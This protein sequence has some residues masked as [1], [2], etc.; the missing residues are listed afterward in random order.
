[1]Y[2]GYYTIYATP[3]YGRSLKSRLTFR[4]I[5]ALIF[6][7]KKKRKSPLSG[8]LRKTGKSQRRYVLQVQNSPIFATFGVR[9]RSYMLIEITYLYVPLILIEFK[10]FYLRHKEEYSSSNLVLYM[11]TWIFVILLP[12]HVLNKTVLKILLLSSL[13][14]LPRQGLIYLHSEE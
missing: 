3:V 6:E 9:T 7:Q 10:L 4:Q 14:P 8:H 5:S 11:V 12:P 2:S 13:P 1:M